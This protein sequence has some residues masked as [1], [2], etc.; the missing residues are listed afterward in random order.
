MSKATVKGWKTWARILA[1]VLA[2]IAGLCLLRLLGPDVMS[3]ETL[4]GWLRPLG[5][6]APLAFVLFLAVR[7]VTLL[8]GQVFTAVGGLLFGTLAASLYSL[9]GSFLA[10]GVVFLLAKKL[11]KR[12]MKRL[13]GQRYAALTRAAKRH[14]FKFALLTCINPLLPTDMM[15]AA[16]AASGARF[17]P[18]AMGVLVG[19]LPGT[20][21]T[22]Q[23]GSALGQGKTILTIV[24]A[25]GMLASLVLGVLLGRRIFSEIE[26]DHQHEKQQHDGAAKRLGEVLRSE[27]PRSIA[28]L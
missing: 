21:L 4:S 26:E 11:G 12:P 3:Q 23:F 10:A 20:F 22:A 28:S 17:W 24:S 1:P 6:Y 27:R 19:T 2:S 25:A 9:L 14:D 16:G 7:P 13:A 5:Q 15:I 8:P 18:T